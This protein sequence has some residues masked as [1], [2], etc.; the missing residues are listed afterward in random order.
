MRIL[1]NPYRTG[2]KPGRRNRGMGAV[3]GLVLAIVLSSCMAQSV[4][5]VGEA[6]IPPPGRVP[7]VAVQV[8]DHDGNPIAG[9]RATAGDSVEESDTSGLVRVRWYG[10]VLSISVEAEGF[11]PAALAVDGVREEPFELSLRPVVLRGAILDRAEFGLPGATVSLGDSHV[12]TD[13][14]GR[15]EFVRPLK[16]TVRVTK[17]GWHD[18]EYVWDGET[19]V[20]EIKMKPMVIRGLHIA[21]NAFTTPEIWQELLDVAEDTVVNALVID[22]KDESG[23]VF[24]DTGVELAHDVNAVDTLFDLDSVTAEM[25]RRGLYKI[26]RIVTFQDPIAARRQTELAIFDSDA[27]RPFRL[28]DQFFLDP[29]DRD[30]RGYALDLAEEVCL[31]G[32]DEIQFDYIRFPDGYPAGFP[33]HVRFDA[34]G[35]PDMREAV[36]TSFLQEAADRL[37]PHGCVVAA[38][39]FGFL[40]SAQGD[41]GIGQNLGV[42]SRTIDVIS[43]M[44]YPSHYSRGWFGFDKPSDHPGEI[45]SQALADGMGRLEGSAVIRPWLQDFYYTPSQVREQIEAAEDQELG[46]MLWNA[47]SRFQTEALQAETPAADVSDTAAQEP[48]F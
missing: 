24:Y 29:T 38:D 35:S 11:F 5:V 45:V 13:R 44:V 47:R 12:R 15:F 25:D 23:R 26:A 9:A 1:P 2:S 42:L 48:L 4:V 18:T 39:I 41:G 27:D 8:L 14:T 17:P 16:G 46:W 7:T 22:V 32:F 33:S 40:T 31:A 36:I 28:G 3:S 20:T 37:H 6:P 30:A 10:E 21:Y 43:P 34:G 19:L